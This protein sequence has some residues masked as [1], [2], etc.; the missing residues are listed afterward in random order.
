MCV[1]VFV[2]ACGLMDLY[3]LVQ[4]PTVMCSVTADHVEMCAP[5][6]LPGMINT[7]VQQTCL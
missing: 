3:L 2:C 6:P 4:L 1:F 7:V 5:F